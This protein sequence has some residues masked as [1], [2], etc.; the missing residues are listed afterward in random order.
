MPLNPPGRVWIY[1]RVSQDDQDGRSCDQQVAL[2]QRDAERESMDV[3]GIY[4]D[5]DRSAS[6]YARQSRE[7]WER[8]VEDMRTHGQTGDRLWGWEISRWTRERVMWGQVVQVVQQK[9]MC[10]W[11]DGKL[12]DAN[13]SQDMFFLDIMLAKAVA[14]VGDT[15]KRIQRNVESLAEEGRPTGWPGYG[16]QYLYDP[17]TGAL[18]EMVPHPEQA[19][20]VREIAERVLAG[21]G[22]RTIARDLNERQVPNSIGYTAGQTMPD[23]KTSRGWTPA[24]ILSMLK[25]PSIMGKRS[26][27]GKIIDAGGWEPIVDPADWWAIQQRL[28]GG[29]KGA[30]RDGSARHLL[31]GIA[32]CGAVREGETCGARVYAQ[33]ARVGGK[34]NR[35]VLVYKCMGT[36]AGASMGHV[37]RKADIIEGHLLSLL[38]DRLEHPDWADAFTAGPDPGETKQAEADLARAR[39]ELE[40]LYADVESGKVSRRLAAADEARLER[41]IA[42]LEEQTRPVRIDPL[43]EEMAQGH[44]QTVWDGWSLE[45][46]R[47]FLRLVAEEVQVLSVGRVGRREISVEESVAVTWKA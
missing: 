30:V 9:Q 24:T 21:H 47:R 2:G 12:H 35:K 17:D 7:D 46:Q 40:E 19:P 38:F 27:R 8:M 16:H 37:S 10:F 44:P 26:H 42:S 5:D 20:I 23:G 6:Q 11:V 39:A 28:N 4:R 3:A 18:R 31:S 15:Q 41:D 14:E 34:T 33:E 25:R 36:H 13:D 32:V 1:A 45:Q 43:V 22:Y 29:Q